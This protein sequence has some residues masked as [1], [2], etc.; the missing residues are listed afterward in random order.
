MARS[1]ASIL[2]VIAASVSFTHGQQPTLVPLA[3]KPLKTGTVKPA[4]WLL[5][6]LRVQG[7]GLSGALLDPSFYEPVYNSQW[8]GGTSTHEDW[9]EILPYVLRGA[10]PQ[11][12]LLNDTAQLARVEAQ[13]NYILAHAGSD[14]WLGPNGSN[15]PGLA[16]FARWLILDAFFSMYGETAIGVRSSEN[17]ARCNNSCVFTP[18]RIHWR[19]E[20]HYRVSR[21]AACRKRATAR[22]SDAL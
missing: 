4:G 15:D 19:P 2:A 12:I 14:G 3:Y 22:H 7:D 8:T 16:Y 10:V 9:I 17:C 1:T 13:M 20:I 11:A 5:R 18:R 6:E 21:L